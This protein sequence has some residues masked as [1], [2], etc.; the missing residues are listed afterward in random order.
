MQ[1]TRDVI[2]YIENSREETMQLLEALCR[3]PAPSGHE[4]ARAE[5]CKKWL[6][7]NGAEG[8]YIDEAL[9][10][11]YPINCEGRDDIVVFVAHTDTV[12]PDTT[13]M[14]YH[15]DGKYAY[16]P[17]IGDDT[18]SLVVM[19]M[20]AK[21]IAKNGLKANRGVLIV[22][23]SCEEGLG[24][25]KGTKQFMSD[26]AGRVKE[27]YSFD[28]E[29][30]NVVIDKCVGSHRYKISFATEGGHSFQ[31]FGKTNAIAVMCELVS[32]LY[33]C[34]VPHVGD[35]RTTYNVG[36]I[37]GGT[38]VNTIAQN[39]EVLY[40]Y[41]SDTLA[42]LD[43]MNK[44]FEDTVAKLQSETDARITVEVIG[45]RPCAGDYDK[46]LFESMVNKCK[47]IC[48]QYI[49][50]ECKT[51]SASTD[52]NIPLSLGIPAVCLGVYMG[53]GAHTREERVE[54]VSIPTGMR[55]AAELMLGYFD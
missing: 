13:P 53:C 35:S 22:A 26:Y 46:E 1:L 40:E 24:N 14:P 33:K 42:C 9:N 49:E 16:S 3:I 7:D 36:I 48:E 47:A 25:L 20:I 19:M 41:R 55:I 38:S 29:T 51:K 15:T 31:A 2:N 4:E 34:E 5:F 10:V 52:C 43:Y 45:K 12:F 44:Y 23:N 21:Y 17:G 27:F 54:I 39:A 37:G 30:Y 28:N 8:V 50:G 32:R 6:E 11:I 18:L